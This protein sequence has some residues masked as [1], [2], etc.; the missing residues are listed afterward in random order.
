MAVKKGLGRGLDALLNEF[1]EQEQAQGVLMV[2]LYDIDTNPEQPRK[3]FDREKL[4]ELA[5]SI[6]RHGIV[7]PLVVR[8]NGVR[9][10]IIAGERRFRAAHLAELKQVPV[11]VS[12]MDPER[13]ME[14][15]L[16]ENLQ[17][18]DLNPIE[19]AAAIRLLM[20]QHDLTQEE[21]SER[22]GKSRPA[23]ANALRLLQLDPQ[24]TEHI[25]T[26]ALSAGHGKMLAGLKNADEQRVLAEKA[27]KNSWSVRRL[28]DELRF[29]HMERPQKEQEEPSPEWKAAIRT[30]RSTL[31]TKVQLVGSE[32]S[33]KL[34]I[35]YYSPDDLD[36]IYQLI[37]KNE[38]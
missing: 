22:I 27:V 19:E 25:K 11:I 8:K 21:V 26:G 35:H 28:E 10:T 3:S 15:A 38:E 13:I 31:Q 18:E 36:R 12:D 16:V 7:Q 1:Q 14:V 30:L 5:V 37:T 9:Y 20:E 34:I 17:R 2:S 6:R 4:E 29:F 33:G 23:I 24:V 32:Q